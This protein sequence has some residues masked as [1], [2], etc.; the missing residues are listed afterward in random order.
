MTT[1][2]EDSNE[3]LGHLME[4]LGEE[5]NGSDEL[6]QLVHDLLV[7]QIELEQQNRELVALHTVLEESRE[8]YADLYDFAPVGYL[9]LD[10]KG[11]I[12]GINLTGA[13]LLGI[14][15]ERIIGHALERFVARG[16]RRTVAAQ[17]AQTLDTQQR[18]V[19]E[20]CPVP[21]R[22]TPTAVDRVLMLESVAESRAGA[23]QIRAILT[24]I[25]ERKIIER[26]RIQR[27]VDAAAARS[28]ERLVSGLERLSAVTSSAFSAESVMDEML[29]IVREQL[30]T[31]RAWL[32]HPCEPSALGVAIIAAVTVPDWPGLPLRN[33]TIPWDPPLK[34]LLRAARDAPE[35][36]IEQQVIAPTALHGGIAPCWSMVAPL[37]AGERDTYLLGVDQRHVEHGWNDDD[38]ALL[39]SFAE[40][41]GQIIETLGVRRALS[42]SE[43][44]FRA[45]FE[46]AAVGLAHIDAQGVFLRVNHKLCGI[47]GYR[48]HELLALSYDAL[49]HPEDRAAVSRFVEKIRSG[50]GTKPHI[51]HRVLTKQGK[52]IWCNLTTAALR[53]GDGR[54]KYDISVIEDISAR[55]SLEEREH[56][57]RAALA[58]VG[59]LTTL[60]A[61]ASGIAH[62]VSQPL[63]A[64]GTYAGGAIER[65]NAAASDQGDIRTALYAIARIAERAGGVIERMRAFSRKTSS[66]SAS[67]DLCE[68]VQ[69][70][71][72]MVAAE[73]KLQGAR[74][75]A[76]CPPHLPRVQGD[77]VQL[78]QVLIN[79]L[80]NGL[81]SM[82]QVP[83]A[84]RCLSV[85][86][87]V[88][89]GIERSDGEVDDQIR[90]IVGDRGQGLLTAN[91]SK[92]FDPFYTT[93]DDGTGLGLSIS[94]TIIEA[95]GGTIWAQ[96]RPGGGAL[97]GFRLPIQR[98]G[99][100]T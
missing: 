84:Q 63:M 80:L 86:V 17:L 69:G 82:E 15:R 65:L 29:R 32:L 27:A 5:G 74:I 88:E 22:L 34:A 91:Q 87:D 57:H 61:M 72:Q 73:T 92:L 48:E 93:K 19:G 51:E 85:D 30:Q 45:T 70:A 78:E 94:R 56:T 38:R 20:L 8:R 42:E 54:F 37:R 99:G 9:T 97:F 13:A 43:E 6:A 96:P 46:Q 3:R 2:E 11:G 55:K 98:D 1:F 33:R 41:I 100:S 81:E 44:R 59:R 95:H 75:E 16:D 76:S 47:M 52:T 24:D 14:P 79:L 58:R 62:E 39:R 50:L 89:V 53:D 68:V 18:Q 49:T 31:E 21:G 60:G 36:V 25:T 83:T 4:R 12:L 67:L 7:H 77:L 35:S 26:E 66:T 23:V 10:H 28:R 40:R 90:L 71:V 64:I